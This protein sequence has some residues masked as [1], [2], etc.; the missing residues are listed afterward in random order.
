MPKNPAHQDNAPPN[1]PI[2][3]H[4]V[5]LEKRAKAHKAHV[6]HGF[7]CRICRDIA[8]FMISQFGVHMSKKWRL[9]VLE[10][11]YS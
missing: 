5:E 3:A 7:N 1:A 10:S 6:R 11:I 4:A 2:A 8:L 9:K